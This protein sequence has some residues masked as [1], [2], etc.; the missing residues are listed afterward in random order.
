M[1]A[2]GNMRFRIEGTAPTAA[3]NDNAKTRGRK[4]EIHANVWVKCVK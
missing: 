3:A 4:I 2:K 1:N